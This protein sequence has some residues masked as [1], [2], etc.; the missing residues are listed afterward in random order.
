MSKLWQRNV[1]LVRRSTCFLLMLNIGCWALGWF[2][3]IFFSTGGRINAVKQECQHTRVRR[4]GWRAGGNEEE[5]VSKLRNWD[6]TDLLLEVTENQTALPLI[7]RRA[8]QRLHSVSSRQLG[9]FLESLVGVTDFRQTMPV[10]TFSLSPEV[11]SSLPAPGLTLV[12]RSP[13]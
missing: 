11:L 1:H 4:M 10:D 9:E 6:R 7:P 13:P 3:C 12:T 8:S 5:P 2:L